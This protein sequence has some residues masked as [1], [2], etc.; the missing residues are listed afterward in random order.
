MMLTSY[1][2]K[3]WKHKSKLFSKSLTKLFKSLK[4]LEDKLF[5]I[6][7]GYNQMWISKSKL[8]YQLKYKNKST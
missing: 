1:R 2:I 4:T 3:P 7:S 6:S 5:K 8:T